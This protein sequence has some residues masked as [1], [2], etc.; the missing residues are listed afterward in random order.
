MEKLDETLRQRLAQAGPASEA[1]PVIVSL[2]EGADPAVLAACGLTIGRH[3][4][5]IGSVSGTIALGDLRR[6]AARG[7]VARI[8]YDGEVRALD[9]P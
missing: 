3:I 7:E 8:E 6:L 2:T 9:R 5:S 1:V 4:A